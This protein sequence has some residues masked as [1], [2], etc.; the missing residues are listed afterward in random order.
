MQK[1]YYLISTDHLEDRIWFQDD[2]DFKAAM[3]FVAVADYVCGIRVLDFILMSNH[4]RFVVYAYL[5][6]ARRFIDYFKL[7]YS[8]YLRK[9]HGVTKFL[10]RNDVDIQELDEHNESV[11]RAIAYVEMNCVAAKICVHPSQY[12]WGCGSVFFGQ[13]EQGRRLGIMSVRAQNRLLHSRI[14]LPQDYIVTADGFISPSSYIPVS[15]VENI[16]STPSRFQYF[17]NKS[18]KARV[19]MS[20]EAMPSFRDQVI[21]SAVNDLCSSLFRKPSLS[22]LTDEEKA[23]MLRQLRYRFSADIAQLSRVT[24]IPYQ[25]ASSLIE[26]Y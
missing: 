16:F 11:E 14:K 24:G 13:K 18:S 5:E 19:R 4:V 10:R 1:H 22:A 26:S 8:K 3:N 6:E 20:E 12:P 2:E 9:R 15:F 7:L 17:L 21:L 25:E 23:E